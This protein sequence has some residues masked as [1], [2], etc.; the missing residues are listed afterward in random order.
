METKVCAAHVFFLRIEW[1]EILA[2]SEEA[3]VRDTVLDVRKKAK[4]K[5]DVGMAAKQ[6]T[7]ARKFELRGSFSV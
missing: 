1:L 5:D 6:R 2:A 3:N 7:G 4:Q